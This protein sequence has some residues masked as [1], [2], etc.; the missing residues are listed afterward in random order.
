MLSM[1]THRLEWRKVIMFKGC[2]VILGVGEV[3]PDLPLSLSLP[4]VKGYG[5]IEFIDFL[6]CLFQFADS[7]LAESGPLFQVVGHGRY[8]PPHTAEHKA[9]AEGE[10]RG[11]VRQQNC[12][13]CFGNISVAAKTAQKAEVWVWEEKGKGVSLPPSLSFSLC[14]SSSPHTRQLLF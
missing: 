4:F 8:S 12:C 6:F 1:M 10:E 7:D 11:Q 14:C 3:L 2:V 5:C 13:C 9:E